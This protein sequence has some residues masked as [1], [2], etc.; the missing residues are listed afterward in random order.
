MSAAPRPYDHELAVLATMHA[1]ER[2]IAPL[3]ERALG[4]RVR[5]SNGIDT[6]RFGT[7]SRDVERTGS[8]LDAAR[9]KIAAAF[10]DTPDAQVAL[11]SEGTFGPHPYIPF[12]P[13]A[14]EIVVLADRASGLELIGHHASPTTNFSHAVVSD[15]GA[16]RAFAER[17]Q[18]PEHGVIVMGVIDGQPAPARAL[19]KDIRNTED[20]EYAVTKV[21]GMCGAA[22]VETDMRAHR[23][24]TRMRAIKR[25][26]LDLVRRF[27]SPCPVC[28]APGFAVTERLAGL[29]CSWC[30]GPTLAIRAEVLSCSACG[31]RIEN[32]VP[33]T[34]A[35]PGQCSDCNP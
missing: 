28:A 22:F 6:D 16:A 2:V 30:G 25:A 7:F 19:I 10:A 26:T 14:R 8:Q 9:A 11:A 20:L 4:L 13:L 34:T 23:N 32:L 33:P 27:R 35:D 31:H 5:V 12:L 24:P 29:P 18:F 17:A 3:L 15:V 21:I 1:K